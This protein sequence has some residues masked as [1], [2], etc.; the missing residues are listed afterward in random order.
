MEKA[1]NRKSLSYWLQMVYSNSQSGWALDIRAPGALT[2]PGLTRFG[3][4]AISLIA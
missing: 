1:V 2:A 3:S 4:N